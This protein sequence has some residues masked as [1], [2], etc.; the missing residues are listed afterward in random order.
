MT[1]KPA[2]TFDWQSELDKA[3]HEHVEDQL[4]ADRLHFKPLFDWALTQE[5][6][7]VNAQRS[8]MQFLTLTSGKD[9]WGRK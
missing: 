1:E 2:R 7:P 6:L 4:F 5:N 8:L 3:I 9:Y